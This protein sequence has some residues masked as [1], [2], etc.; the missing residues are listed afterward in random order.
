MVS[1]P[2]T[3]LSLVLFP[4]LAESDPF[5]SNQSSSSEL[6]CELWQERVVKREQGVCA[7]SEQHLHAGGVNGADAGMKRGINT[8]RF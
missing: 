7:T 5:A 8:C 3:S 1:N 2:L 6:C 4:R